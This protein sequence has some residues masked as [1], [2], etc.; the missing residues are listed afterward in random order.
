MEILIPEERL[1]KLTIKIIKSMEIRGLYRV[2]ANVTKS[3]DFIV[4][5]FFETVSDS[6][7]YAIVKN[8]VE[9]MINSLL[10]TKALVLPIPYSEAKYHLREPKNI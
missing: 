2:H 5:L 6:N 8:D 1:V 4:A 3:G 7:F 10:G 9:D